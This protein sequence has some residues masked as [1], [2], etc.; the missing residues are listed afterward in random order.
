MKK[1]KLLL[2]SCVAKD[3][4]VRLRADGHDV[5]TV[6]E[7]GVDPGDPMILASAASEGRA[8]VTIDHD[9]GTLVFRDGAKHL[10]VLRLRQLGAV[11]LAARASEIVAL[12][13]DDL[14]AGAFVT[15]DGDRVRVTKR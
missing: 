9:F 6:T 12:Y 2:D 14:E 7:R 5:A 10:G 11:A 8:I 15:D 13:G 1:R 4:A 3:V